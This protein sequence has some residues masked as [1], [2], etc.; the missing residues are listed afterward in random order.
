MLLDV[1]VLGVRNRSALDMFLC[2]F[3]KGFC[4][5]AT[6]YRFAQFSDNPQWKG[7][8]LKTLLDIL[9][10]HPDAAYSIYW[11]NPHPESV[12]AAMAFFTKDAGLIVGLSVPE[13]KASE[14]LG[15]L[16]KATGSN[17]GAT[18]FEQPPPGSVR[19]FRELAGK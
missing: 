5:A 13:E 9:D 3:A 10:A 15:Q 18:L 2:T 14:Y 19:E 6:E 8:D 17:T 7:P 1:Y 16:K 11:T 4:E 12:K